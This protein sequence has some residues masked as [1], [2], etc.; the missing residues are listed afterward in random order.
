VEPAAQA[1]VEAI[2]SGAPET[3]HRAGMM[4]LSAAAPTG[5]A[6]RLEPPDPVGPAALI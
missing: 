6:R 1:R 5:Q 2:G 3:S 4:S